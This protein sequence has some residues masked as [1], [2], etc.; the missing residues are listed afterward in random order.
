[1]GQS[2]NVAEPN[3]AFLDLRRACNAGRFRTREQQASGNCACSVE[4]LVFAELCESHVL[5]IRVVLGPNQRADAF[6]QGRA[7]GG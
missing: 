5:P 6:E 2:L 7:R 4:R 1:V 3:I